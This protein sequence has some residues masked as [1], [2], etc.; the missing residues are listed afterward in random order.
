MH[1][2]IVYLSWPA[3]EI[4]G[5]IKMAYR[6]VESLVAAGFDSI[7]ATPDGAAPNWF[8]TSAST[9]MLDSLVPHL[10]VLVFPENHAGLLRH[11]RSW[12]NAKIVFCQNQFMVH[13]GLAGAR[14][15][16]DYGVG[17][18]IAVG[19]H[20][21]DYCER[22]FPGLR[23]ELV[24]VFVD[25]EMFRFSPQKRLQIAFSPRKRPMEAE[26]IKDLFRA[27]NPQWSD[28]PWI[29]IAGMSE[30]DVARALRES[31][32]YLALCRFEACPLTILEAFS[33]GC[34]VAGFHGF[35]ARDYVT[36]SNGYW[37][38]E[39]DCLDA[40]VQLARAMQTATAKTSSHSD[41]ASAAITDAR[42]Y[43]RKRLEEKLVAYW[44][45]F[46]GRHHKPTE[47]NVASASPR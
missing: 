12:P 26:F 39:D 22:R 27:E 30:A 9:A 23:T 25:G 28:V 24:P 29:P 6:H 20:V 38:V 8:S 46:F 41:I 16:S 18:I 2:R 42:R 1:P 37:A 14:C 45:G 19:R 40:T 5:G 33:C 32:V 43:N 34:L 13:R 11:F 31:A 17:E 3:N 21:V 10:D 47:T 36:A 44:S 35:G 15:Y 7:V 4:T